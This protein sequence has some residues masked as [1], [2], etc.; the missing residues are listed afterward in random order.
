MNSDPNYRF[1]VAYSQEL[2][3]V[4]GTASLI[5]EQKFI[6]NLAKVG[7]IEDVV[8]DSTARGK[9]VGKRL[10]ELLTQFA[11]SEGCYKVILDCHVENSGFYERCGY[12][13]KGVYMAKYFDSSS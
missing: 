5:L 12:A 8:V 10:I 13:Q 7:H 3:K 9:G 11:K 4:V 1:L 6:R 2:K